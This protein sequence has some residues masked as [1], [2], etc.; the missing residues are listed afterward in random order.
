MTTHVNV[1]DYMSPEWRRAA[2]L[3]ILRNPSQN[4]VE[5]TL[6]LAA[7]ETIKNFLIANDFAIDMNDGYHLQVTDKGVKE[8]FER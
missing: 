7:I 6:R 3:T 1:D 5:Q 4:A 8:F 2:A